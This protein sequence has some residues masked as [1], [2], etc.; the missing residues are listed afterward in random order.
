[1]FGRKKPTPAS[2]TWSSRKFMI[3][4][5]QEINEEELQTVIGGQTF[6]QPQTIQSR[7]VDHLE[8]QLQDFRRRVQTVTPRILPW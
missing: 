2:Q 6:Y 5:F 7:H 4:A 3:P 8:S 1:M